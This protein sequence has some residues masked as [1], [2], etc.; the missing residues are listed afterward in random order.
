MQGRCQEGALGISARTVRYPRAVNVCCTQASF[1]SS[2][3]RGLFGPLW[4]RRPIACKMNVMD[5]DKFALVGLP[6]M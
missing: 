4:G 2:C 1:T 3:V 5:L 6:A